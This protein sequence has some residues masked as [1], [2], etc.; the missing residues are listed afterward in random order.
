MKQADDIIRS[1]TAA[2]CLQQ[3]TFNGNTEQSG[4]YCIMMCG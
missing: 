3:V 4:I 2:K 1:Y